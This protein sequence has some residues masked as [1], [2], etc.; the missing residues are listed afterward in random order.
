[1]EH[2]VATTDSEP[3]LTTLLLTTTRELT[4]AVEGH[5][6]DTGLGIDDWLVIATLATEP[7]LTMTELR[8]RTLTSAPTLSRVTDRLVSRALLFRE[9]DAADRRRVRLHLTKRGAELHQKL[10]PVIRAAEREWTAAND[11][12]LL[13]ISLQRHGFGTR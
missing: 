5:L 6:S 2:H 7:E 4:A 3:S 1:M 9:V 8:H 10:D 13:L 11:G 12:N